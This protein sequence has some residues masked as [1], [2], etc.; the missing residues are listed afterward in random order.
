M[1]R[2][3]LKTHIPKNASA[4]RESETAGLSVELL[5][6][7]DFLV[8]RLGLG[9]MRLTGKGVWGEPSDRSEA[10]RVVRRAVELGVN[11]IDTADSYGPDVSEGI[12]A[13]ALYPYPEDVVV[14]TKGGLER[15]GP[16]Q[17]VENGRPKHLN[18]ACEEAGLSCGG[19]F[20]TADT[21]SSCKSDPRTPDGERL[22]STSSAD[23]AP[24]T[25]RVPDAAEQ[26]GTAAA[27]SKIHDSLALP[28]SLRVNGARRELRLDP[29]TSLLDALRDHLQLSGTKKGCDQ[30][31]C[32]AC[33]V[34]VNGQRVLSCLSLAL[35]HEGDDVTTIEGLVNDE[36]GHVL[37]AGFIEADGF[38]CGYC[39]PGQICSAV[40]MLHEFG[41]GVPSA[42][43]PIASLSATTLNDEELKER[44]SGN[45][46]RCGAYVGICDAIRTAH[47]RLGRQAR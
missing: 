10:I 16:D 46:C 36:T 32:G 39:T 26:Q 6:A 4:K 43:T 34:L 28:L 9:T 37:Q 38:Q 23:E 8:A 31:A 19:R 17:W 12:I 35:Q 5:I 15:P 14:A 42:V 24:M 29:R 2:R 41:Q 25:P 20:R 21:N 18:S 3:H 1:R 27:Q 33:T 13:E 7:D 11:F 45:L 22:A 40:G 47:E 44:M 30:G